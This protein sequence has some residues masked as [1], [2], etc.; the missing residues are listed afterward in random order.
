M[1][2]ILYVRSYVIG[3]KVTEILLTIGV[4]YFIIAIVVHCFMHRWR[5]MIHKWIKWLRHRKIFK[6]KT[7][8]SKVSL[9]MESLSSKIADV[10]YNYR[11]FRE[12][13]VEYDN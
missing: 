10:T 2:L 8:Q 1:T 3:V 7:S 9:E 6:V 11:E 5:S 13:L 12:P 4:T